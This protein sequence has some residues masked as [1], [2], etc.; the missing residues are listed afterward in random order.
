M[1]RIFFI[2]IILIC[3][4]LCD[5]PPCA[6]AKE[7]P[8]SENPQPPQQKPIFFPSEPDEP[9]LQYLAS[10]STS[11]D[12]EK[13]PSAFKKFIVGDEKKTKAIAKPYG[14]TVHK[15][16]IYVCD[17][18]HNAIDI[19]NFKTRKFEY[20]RP[21]DDAQL[22][23]PISLDFDNEDNMYVA[24]SRRGQILVFDQRANYIGAIGS[25]SEFKPTGVMVQDDKIFVCDLKS[26]SVKVY[27]VKDWVHLQ[28]IPGANSKDVAKLFSPTN[29]AG[30]QEGNLYVSDTGG[31]RIQVYNRKGGFIR[32]IG[33]HG[34]AFGQFARP[35]GIAV[36]K[37]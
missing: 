4:I 27:R 6:N 16:K 14:V 30:D 24:D 10:F 21:Q 19:L 11:K 28:N 35:K 26:H 13:P 5:S 9:R 37:E 18:V 36:D 3:F 17:T 2:P 31:F 23:D 7:K 1:K 33:G 15:G 32:S 20:F 25:K 8:Q 22:M 12:F 34:D 29:L